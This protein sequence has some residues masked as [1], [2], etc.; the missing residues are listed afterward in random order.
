MTVGFIRFCYYLDEDSDRILETIMEKMKAAGYQYNH[1][2]GNTVL[3]AACPRV[4]YELTSGNT[5]IIALKYLEEGADWEQ[6]VIK[7]RE[8]DQ[9]GSIREEDLLGKVTLLL[10][11]GEEWG[12][13]C[14]SAQEMVGRRK[15]LSIQMPGGRLLRFAFR[16]T[17]TVYLCSVPQGDDALAGFIQQRLP[18]IETHSL[19]LSMLSGVFRDRTAMIARENQELDQKLSQLLHTNLVH[20]S[21]DLREAAELES[22]MN[23]LSLSYGII[24]GNHLSLIEGY[25]QLQQL[26]NSFER[27]LG[28]DPAITIRTDQMEAVTRPHKARLA[29]MSSTEKQLR[30]SRD[31]HQAAIEVVRSRIDIMN[32]RTNI[33]T[34]E[35]IKALMELNTSMQQQSLVFQYAAGLIEFI[36]LAYYSHSLWKNLAHH[37]Y[38]II[39][40]W[41]QFA[42]VMGFSGITVYCT[43]LL[44]EYL[45]GEHRV[46]RKMILALVPLL[47]IILTVIIGSAM[48]G[49]AAGGESAAH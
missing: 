46:K 44:A 10:S 30:S 20:E 28:T 40:A 2:A 1:A 32:S 34:Q 29:E 42:F 33:A 22:Q 8:L 25:N 45:Q 48:L 5:G 47:F 31:N 13:F 6:A 37:A 36:V 17:E 3:D 4:F 7:L 23:E 26:L 41:I 18:I 11:V 39:P 49:G 43:H 21:S 16:S 19:K 9:M 35:K 15:G 27:L 14:Q 12:Q 24:A 38:T